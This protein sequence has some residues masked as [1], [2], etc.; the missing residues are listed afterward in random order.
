MIDNTIYRSKYNS[1]QKNHPYLKCLELFKEK[2]KMDIDEMIDAH[3]K[4]FGIKLKR[5]IA[6][7]RIYRL[8][9]KGYIKNVGLK[10]YRLIKKQEK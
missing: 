5:G 3:E 7:Q 9:L 6:H 1:R 8:C 2:N 4:K 10:T